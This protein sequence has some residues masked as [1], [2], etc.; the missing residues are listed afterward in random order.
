M[1]E[2][3]LAGRRWTPPLARTVGD[4]LGSD[5]S[6]SDQNGVERRERISTRREKGR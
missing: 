1:R 6:L 2:A 5:T 3:R 4:R